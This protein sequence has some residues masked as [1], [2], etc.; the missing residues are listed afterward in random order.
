MDPTVER[1][2]PVG[3]SLARSATADAVADARSAHRGVGVVPEPLPDLL[4]MVTPMGPYTVR[5]GPGLLPV[6]AT[7]SPPDQRGM[8]GLRGVD[9]RQRHSR[10]ADSRA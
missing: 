10:W 2:V 9:V 5:V 3:L 1:V 6:V 7:A 4:M 8:P